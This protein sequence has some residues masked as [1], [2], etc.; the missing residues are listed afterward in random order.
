MLEKW[1]E[2]KIPIIIVVFMLSM[3]FSISY[4]GNPEEEYSDKV[5]RKNVLE[6]VREEKAYQE[7]SQIGSNATSSE[8]HMSRIAQPINLSNIS[9]EDQQFIA[10]IMESD[11]IIVNDIKFAIDSANK[12]NYRNFETSGMVIKN[13]SAKYLKMTRSLNV[14]YSLK[15]MSD[16]YINA[17]EDFY[18]VGK[19]IESG[20]KNPS[21]K[22]IERSIDYLRKATKHMNNVRNVLQAS[23]MNPDISVNSNNMNITSNSSTKRRL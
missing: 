6:N 14:S 16:E 18:N 12:S 21:S 2:W 23:S 17:L 1:N 10:L 22:D 7:N 15:N 13:D 8:A 5:G 20:S 19:Y 11:K 9:R 4:F 3:V